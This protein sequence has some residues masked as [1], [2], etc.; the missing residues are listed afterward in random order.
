VDFLSPA[1]S[2]E[3]HQNLLD[4]H[5]KKPVGFLREM[6]SDASKRC[7]SITIRHS[8]HLILETIPLKCVRSSWDAINVS[9]NNR[10]RVLLSKM[11]ARSFWA[12]DNIMGLG[13]QIMSRS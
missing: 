10:I 11:V 9:P 2:K 8:S 13:V 1:G 6:F 12:N 4:H 7:I 5:V 3:Q